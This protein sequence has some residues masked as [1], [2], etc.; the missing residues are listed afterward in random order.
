MSLTLKI[1][2]IVL[3]AQPLLGESYQGEEK[4]RIYK[5]RFSNV[6][7]TVKLLRKAYEYGLN[8]ISIMSLL[9]SELFKKLLEAIRILKRQGIIFQV[10]PCISIP[11]RLGNYP[12]DDYR[13]W[14][15]YF[16][17]ECRFCD[18]NELKEKY[19][20]D[21]ILL[22]RPKWRE[23][24]LRM[25]KEGEPYRQ[26]EYEKITVDFKLLESKIAVF[27]EFEKAFINLGSECDFLA[28][29]GRLD[30]LNTIIESLKAKG[31]SYIFISSHHAGSTIPII[32]NS[33][34]KVEGYTTPVNAIGALMLPTY[35][36]AMKA[37]RPVAEKIIAIKPLAGG[38]VNPYVAF[39]FL[40]NNK[41]EHFMLGMASFEELKADLEAA[42][43]IFQNT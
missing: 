32:E 9:D 11:L 20:N 10:A 38:R 26:E 30:I 3:G 6:Q 2:N 40:V 36:E 15:T 22:T 28:I 34:L 24:F 23:N 25:L 21:P 14:L 37:I 1:P 4:N 41:I 35:D 8:T 27:E 13:R 17:Y 12:V 29:A 16:H 33:N 39:T 7:Y 42:R 19:L 18:P 5:A 31:F 43:R